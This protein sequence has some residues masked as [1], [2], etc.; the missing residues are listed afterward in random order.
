M[1]RKNIQQ[2]VEEQD[3]VSESQ[4]S[5]DA[6]EIHEDKPSDQDRMHDENLRNK[7]KKLLKDDPDL[8]FHIMR[9]KPS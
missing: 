9:K 6:N 5:D 4:D 1:F 2:S 3:Y 7:C 8:L